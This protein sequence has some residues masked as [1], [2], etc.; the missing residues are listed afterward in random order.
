MRPNVRSR[1]VTKCEQIMANESKK[2]ISNVLSELADT[3]PPAGVDLVEN[4]RLPQTRWE[5]DHIK[6]VHAVSMGRGHKRELRLFTKWKDTMQRAEDFQEEDG[7]LPAQI[8]L[9]LLLASTTRQQGVMQLPSD[10]GSLYDAGLTRYHALYK[11]QR[12]V[13]IRRTEEFRVALNTFALDLGLD[14]QVLGVRK[15]SS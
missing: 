2:L 15:G 7:S 8:R 11:S 10:A 3:V 9:T 5:F 6:E 14:R 1:H 4:A 12:P 13:D